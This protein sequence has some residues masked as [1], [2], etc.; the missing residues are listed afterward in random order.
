MNGLHH[1]FVYGTLKK[2]QCREK[3]WPIPAVAVRPA[4]TLGELYD[5]GPYPALL[6][7]KRRIAGQLWSFNQCDIWAV[8]QALDSIEC[9]NQPNVPNEYDRV[10]VPVFTLEQLEHQAEIYLFA[11][12]EQLQTTARLVEASLSFQNQRYV[13]WP[14]GA[15]WP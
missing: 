13:V 7:G 6:R 3:C 2:G 1:V 12:P 11:N 5:L 15:N 14:P 4:W 9:T 10:S 8:T